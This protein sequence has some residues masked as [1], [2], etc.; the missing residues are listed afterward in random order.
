MVGIVSAACLN[1]LEFLSGG[2]MFK[3]TYVEK[4]MKVRR[5]VPGGRREDE[6]EVNRESQHLSRHAISHPPLL[7]PPC[8]PFALFPSAHLSFAKI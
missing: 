1:Y 4:L 7:S 5:R 2:W 3:E 8:L 6:S